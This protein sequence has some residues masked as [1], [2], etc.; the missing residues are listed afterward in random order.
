MINNTGEQAIRQC[1]KASLAELVILEEKLLKDIE[2]IERFT[3]IDVEEV[4]QDNNEQ[5]DDSHPQQ[6]PLVAP[7]PNPKLAQEKE[8]EIIEAIMRAK[9]AIAENA[10]QKTEEFEYR[11]EG[12]FP[13]LPKPLNKKEKVDLLNKAYGVKPKAPP[14]PIDKVKKVVKPSESK[15]TFKGFGKNF[16]EKNPQKITTQGRQAS[17]G[18]STI[19]ASTPRSSSRG[20]SITNTKNSLEKPQKPVTTQNRKPINRRNEWQDFSAAPLAPKPS[21]SSDTGST[22]LPPTPVNSE[23]LLQI[24]PRTTADKL[25]QFPPPTKIPVRPS[26]TGAN[27]FASVLKSMQSKTSVNKVDVSWLNTVSSLLAKGRRLAEDYSRTVAVELKRQKIDTCCQKMLE[28]FALQ[29]AANAATYEKAMTSKNRKKES[30]SDRSDDEAE[31]SGGKKIDIPRLTKLFV[32]PEEVELLHHSKLFSSVSHVPQA[33]N[34]LSD[35]EEIIKMRQFE[36]MGYFAKEGDEFEDMVAMLSG[37]GVKSPYGQEL[38]SDM[39][40]CWFCGEQ[41][42][43]VYGQLKEKKAALESAIGKIMQGL[44]KPEIL[45]VLKHIEVPLKEEK[46]DPLIEEFTEQDPK[47]KSIE[48]KS[49]YLNVVKFQ[50]MKQVRASFENLQSSEV[51]KGINYEPNHYKSFLKRLR[52][53]DMLMKPNSRLPLLFHTNFPHETDGT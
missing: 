3:K 21:L 47:L 36:K 25:P 11:P 34:A 51:E 53:L 37:K 44:S 31:E 15:Y 29:T 27:P 12:M 4:S 43:T 30:D 38:L 6:Q 32:R 28:T 35:N 9:E 19:A 5:M 10:Q 26:P 2:K 49:N 41:F 14:K 17:R 8:K 7:P 42:A 46:P 22:Q 40:A 33:F 50:M 1:L 20:K 45:E 39:Y 16:C 18:K 24:A 48:L 23:H 52:E 13:E